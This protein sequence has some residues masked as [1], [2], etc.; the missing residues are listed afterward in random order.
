MA[1]EPLV[2]SGVDSWHHKSNKNPTLEQSRGELI[3]NDATKKVTFGVQKKLSFDAKY[4][5]VIL[6]VNYDDVRRVIFDEATSI[7]S[8]IN[9]FKQVHESNKRAN[10]DYWMYMEYVTPAGSVETHMFQIPEK[11]APQVLERAKRDFGDRVVVTDVRRGVDIDRRTL[12]DLHSKHSFEL[13]EDLKNHP[14]P[15]LMPDKALIVVVYPV[16]ESFKSGL[17]IGPKEK[18]SPGNDPFTNQVKIHANDRVVLVNKVG[19]YGFAYLDPGAYQIAVQSVFANAL[20]ITLEAGKAYYFL[21]EDIQP[22]MPSLEIQLSQHSK[23]LVMFRLSE[24]YY[25]TWQRKG[26]E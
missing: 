2:A 13:A 10:G 15:E 25:G 16:F 14:I 5:D 19:R 23:E 6:E 3:L 9:Q 4:D 1:Q 12:K 22:D 7:R 21:E 20:Q 18:H 24:S 8:R 11:F 26:K 17:V